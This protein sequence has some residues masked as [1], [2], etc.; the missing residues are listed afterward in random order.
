MASF[1]YTS[2]SA[3]AVG[4]IDAPDRSS[5]LRQLMSRGISPKSIEQVGGE[6]VRKAKPA[7]ASN[8]GHGK[9]NGKTNGRADADKS[10]GLAIDKPSVATA[11]G[12][13]KAN[14][15]AM[16]NNSGQLVTTRRSSMSLGD[17]ANFIR[18]LATALQAGLPIVPA[19]RTLGKS[20]RSPGQ[21]AMLAFMIEQVETGRTLSQA[22]SSWGKPFGDL[23]VS[24]IRAGEVSGRLAETLEQA[25]DLLERELKLRRTVMS[26]TLYPIILLVM[27]SGAIV[28]VSTFI[29][30]K[31]LEPLKGQNIPMPLPTQIVQGFAWFVGA[32]WWAI[33]VA[34]LVGVF[35]WVRART[36]PASRLVIDNALVRMPLVGPVLRD[37]AVARFTRTLGTLVKSGLP[38]LQALRLTAATMTN[39]ALRAAVLGVC[40]E[41]AGGKTIAEPLEKTGIFPPLLV[42]IVSLGERSGKLPELLGQAANALD[43]RTETRVKVLSSVLPPILVVLVACVVGVV[44]AAILLPLLSMQDAASRL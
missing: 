38:V 4:T 3:G 33:A 37:A 15:G 35:A 29:V 31:I 1:K 13:A 18:E 7:P 19:M 27:V 2:M 26:A 16:V 32:Y 40:D 43:G 42:Q 20:G 44:V 28:V 41:V 8:N 24:L 14:D 12:R 5:A 9:A 17:T 22:C 23:I 25:G 34:I 11:A 10:S 30:P 36:L 6:D 39:H 21:R